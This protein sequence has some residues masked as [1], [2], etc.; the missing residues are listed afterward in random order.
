[1]FMS[2]GRGMATRT[3]LS[4]GSLA[5]VVTVTRSL[6]TLLTLP[7][8]LALLGV[9]GLGV[10]MTGLSMLGIIGFLNGGLSSALVTAVARSRS[11]RALLLQNAASGFY[12]SV[13]CSGVI[14]LI[15]LP[16][17]LIIDWHGIL[18]LSDAI[19]PQEVTGLFLVLLATLVL[20]FPA[21]VP[22]FIMLGNQQGYLA[23]I[24][25]LVATIASATA[26]FVSISFGMSLPL[27][28][29]AWL[30]VQVSMFG[31]IGALYLRRA[32]IPVLAATHIDWPTLTK[33]FREFRQFTVHQVSF[34][35]S[36]HTDLTLISIIAGPTASAS[37][38]IAQRLFGLPTMIIVAMNQAIWPVLADADRRGDILSVKRTYLLAL[39]IFVPSGLVIAAVFSIFYDQI[40]Y[41]WLSQNVVTDRLLLIGMI[42]WMTVTIFVHTTEMVLRAR[43]NAPFLMRCMIAMLVVNLPVSVA[44]IH[45]VGQ[46]GAIWGT[47]IAFIPCLAIPYATMVRTQFRTAPATASSSKPLDGIIPD[48]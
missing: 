47:V 20:G 13:G 32:R 38:G 36:S 44:L 8:L 43:G 31:L 23:H 25:D 35:L 21:N 9:E 11:D 41:F 1:M 22:K 10:W 37:Y 18:H 45:L 15:G 19:V 17:V 14:L 27:L 6:V 42:C 4:T 7:S 28:A 46:A 3:I 24:A 2:L 48:R 12:L 40:L 29:A 39:G 30:I 5:I 34:A 26:L 33:L 16:V